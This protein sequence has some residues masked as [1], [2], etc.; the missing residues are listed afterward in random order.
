[1]RV[2]VYTLCH[3]KQKNAYWQVSNMMCVDPIPLM[4]NVHSI[5]QWSQMYV[6]I[7]YYTMVSGGHWKLKGRDYIT[8]LGCQITSAQSLAVWATCTLNRALRSQQD[9]HVSRTAHGFVRSPTSM[10][11]E[12]VYHSR[13]SR[14]EHPGFGGYLLLKQSHLTNDPPESRKRDIDRLLIRKHPTDKC[15]YCLIQSLKFGMPWPT[16]VRCLLFGASFGCSIIFY[17]EIN[18]INPVWKLGILFVTRQA[19]PKVHQAHSFERNHPKMAHFGSLNHQDISTH[20]SPGAFPHGHRWR[21]LQSIPSYRASA[22]FF[23]WPF[24]AR[25]REWP[26]H[27]RACLKMVD[28]L[29]SG[30]FPTWE[31]PGRHRK[32]QQSKS[33]NHHPWRLDENWGYPHDDSESP[34]WQFDRD[35]FFDLM[36]AWPGCPWVELDESHPFKVLDDKNMMARFRC[37]RIVR[38]C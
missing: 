11:I 5:P 23:R 9:C 17:P 8:C 26:R 1:M 10:Q 28:T 37:V 4:L 27:A 38:T 36:L 16:K 18:Q 15:V 34:Q 32:C 7:R 21:A 35:Y 2:L 24:S 20:S 6:P 19:Q 33:E 13:L 31:I 12:T 3:F 25:G 29:K 14:I 30:S 22:A